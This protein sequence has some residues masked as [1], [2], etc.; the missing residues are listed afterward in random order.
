ME[1]G[2]LSD[3]EAILNVAL[4][5]HQRADNGGGV[6][7]TSV[8]LAEVLVLERKLPESEAAL[9]RYE[10][11]LRRNENWRGEHVAPELYGEGR[12]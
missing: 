4:T 11:V 10:E 2:K 6:A 3:A 8:Q 7:I 12:D 1:E 9:E 5:E